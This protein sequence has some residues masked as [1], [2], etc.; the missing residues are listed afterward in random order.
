MQTLRKLPTIVPIAN[1]PTPK[2]QQDRSGRQHRAA[3]SP[4]DISKSARSVRI[5]QSTSAGSRARG[6]GRPPPRRFARSCP[7][8]RRRPPD[9]GASAL[10]GRRRARRWSRPASRPAG[11]RGRGDRPGAGPTA[12]AGSVQSQTT[13]PNDR[14]ALRFVSRSTTPPPVARMAPGWAAVSSESTRSSQSRKNGSPSSAKIAAIDR[15]ELFL[16]F[17][18]GIQERP[19]QSF[20]QNSAD[21]RLAGAA[22]PHQRQTLPILRPGRS[23]AEWSEL[24][25]QDVAHQAHRRVFAGVEPELVRRP[26]G[27]TSPRR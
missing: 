19:H 18:I 22:G 26:G 24:A 14:S 13:N 4:H 5:S 1:S 12:R 27:R 9:T 6:S 15:P 8:P 23:F 25:F 10:R 16:Q 17:D 2:V 7:R 3:P 20:G 21:G 11:R